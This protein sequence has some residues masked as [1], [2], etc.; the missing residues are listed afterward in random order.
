MRREEYVASCVPYCSSSA[1]PLC[2]APCGICSKLSGVGGC[3]QILYDGL[4]PCVADGLLTYAVCG[5]PARKAVAKLLLEDEEPA[6]VLITLLGGLHVKGEDDVK[7]IFPFDTHHA[8]SSVSLITKVWPAYDESRAGCYYLDS[9]AKG[10]DDWNM[11]EERPV[12][13]AQRH[14]V[15]REWGWLK[16]PSVVVSKKRREDS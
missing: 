6:V 13:E 14:S 7:G 1:V 16:E 3:A 5:G 12:A 4:A 10:R 9:A 15:L 8:V 11:Y 2:N